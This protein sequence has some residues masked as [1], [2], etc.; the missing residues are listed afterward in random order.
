MIVF[1]RCSTNN[2]ACTVFNLFQEAVGNF[3]L[4]SRVRSDKGGENIDVAWFMLN[5]PQRGPDRGSHIAGH[6]VH[7][8][9]IERLWRDPF[10]GCTYVF[11]HLFYH[12]EEVR[13]LEPDNEMHL[14]ALHFIFLP[15]INRHLHTFESGHNCGLIST[16]QNNSPEQLWIRGMLAV[17]NADF[18]VAE[19]FREEV[20]QDI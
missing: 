15:R 20:N 2:N 17:R 12:M 10:T 3:G 6:S 1:L 16:E 7:N 19:E 18:R 13:I 11:Y 4:P 9:G 14:A 8:Q 5:H